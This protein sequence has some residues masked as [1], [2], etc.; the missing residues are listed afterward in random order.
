MKLYAVCLLYVCVMH[1]MHILTVILYSTT[2]E[3][4]IKGI[5][6]AVQNNTLSSCNLSQ[7]V[8]HYLM[9]NNKIT[10][11]VIKININHIDPK[12]LNGSVDFSPKSD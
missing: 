9:V 2:C 5:F 12:L 4:E 10:R 1:I 11:M 7:K 8:V 3:V 6:G